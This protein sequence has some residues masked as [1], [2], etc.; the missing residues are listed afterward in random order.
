MACHSD[1]DGAVKG[2]GMGDALAAALPNGGL[3]AIQQHIGSFKQH[4]GSFK[5]HIN[6]KYI[7]Y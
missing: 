3:T 4:I 1:Y 6:S 5:Q 2:G 7:T